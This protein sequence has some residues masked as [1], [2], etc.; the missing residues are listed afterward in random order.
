[1]KPQIK[2][3]KLNDHNKVNS[4]LILLMA[5]LP[6]LLF[7]MKLQAASISEELLKA[8]FEGSARTP[9]NNTV[10]MNTTAMQ[11]VAIHT[12]E[13]KTELLPSVE[14]TVS[15]KR[16][17]AMQQGQRC[18]VNVSVDFKANTV[19]DYCLYLSTK[20]TALQC[21]RKTKQGTMS[22]AVDSNVD[23]EFIVQRSLAEQSKKQALPLARTKVK[24]AWVHEKKGKPRMS[25]RL[26]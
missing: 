13:N 3:L 10:A 20:T 5:T 19:D 18:Y 7:S 26:F 21:W 12:A 8:D 15:P 9:V 24:M 2:P 1:M 22:Y 14:L 11:T 4:L 25:W 6:I 17:V 16:C 23:I